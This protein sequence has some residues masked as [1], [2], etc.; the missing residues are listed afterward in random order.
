MRNEAVMTETIQ[1]LRRGL[2]VLRILQANGTSSLHDLHLATRISKPSLLRI[3]NTLAEAGAV[4]RRLADGRFRAGAGLLRMDRRGDRHDRIAEAAGPVLDELCRKISWPSDVLVPAGAHLEIR[5]TSRTHSPFR[6]HIPTVGQ[7]VG[8]L[9]TGVGRAYLAFCPDKERERIL[10]RLRKS[11]MQDDRLVHDPQRLSKILAGTRARGYG[12]RDEHFFGG[13]YGA[14]PLHDGLAAL[15][16]PLMGAHRVY[17]VMN[18]LWIKTA[19][20]VEQFAQQHLGEL[21]EA[22]RQIVVGVETQHDLG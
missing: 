21:R 12:I 8:W 19:F 14:P 9:L 20:T 7:S 22:A 6:I 3:L 17:G 13:G 15:A 11:K 16:V 4:T 1:G 2:Q 10:Q 18:I 5:E